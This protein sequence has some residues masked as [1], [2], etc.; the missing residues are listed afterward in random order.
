MT[1]LPHSQP[2]TI[3]RPILSRLAGIYYLRTFWPILVGPTVF[4]IALLIFG[5]N[6]MLRLFGVFLA[7]WPGTVFVR[8]L[9][10]VGKPAKAWAKPTVM[11]FDHDALYFESQTEPVSRLKLKRT[12]IRRV[13]RLAGYYI[14]QFRKFEFVP[15]PILALEEGSSRTQFEESF[16]I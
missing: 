16:G 8:A 2:Y 5:P 15:V 4:G 13:F 1:A 7:A 12:S 3:P 6:Q 10:L 14:V 9:I 11:S